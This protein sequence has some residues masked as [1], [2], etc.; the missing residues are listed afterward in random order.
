MS[1]IKM[2]RQ[3][4]KDVCVMQGSF[5]GMGLM[6]A[7]CGYWQVLALVAAV[8]VALWVVLSAVW[9]LIE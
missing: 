2:T 6:F 4:W 7:A 8:E 5:L 9:H 3:D 1:T